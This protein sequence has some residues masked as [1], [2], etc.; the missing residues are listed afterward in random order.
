MTEQKNLHDFK[1]N[2]RIAF[3][4]KFDANGVDD[5]EPLFID[6]QREN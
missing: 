5:A 4:P 3:K 6:F 1:P 2:A